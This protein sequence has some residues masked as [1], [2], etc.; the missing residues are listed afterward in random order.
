MG[1]AIFGPLVKIVR[2]N[3][4]GASVNIQ[5]LSGSTN[6]TSTF[7]VLGSKFVKLNEYENPLWQAYEEDVALMNVR[8]VITLQSN[9]VVGLGKLAAV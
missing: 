1:L 4:T 9:E 3:A 8:T 5:I 6:E 2:S 7:A